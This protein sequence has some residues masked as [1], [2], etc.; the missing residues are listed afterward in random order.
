[1]FKYQVEQGGKTEPG[2]SEIEICVELM[3]R[4]NIRKNFFTVSV[5]KHWNRL[6][7]EAAESLSFEILRSH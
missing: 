4:L 3:F 6:H 1:V 5:V 2:C 7:R